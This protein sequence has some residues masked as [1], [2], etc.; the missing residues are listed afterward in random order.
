MGT[1]SDD[2]LA[3]LGLSMTDFLAALPRVQPSATREG[4]GV[5]PDVTWE[6]IGALEAVREELQLN[7]VEPIVH[8]DKYPQTQSTHL[9]YLPHTHALLSD[10]VLPNRYA[11]LGIKVPAG[12]LL[13]GPPGCGKTLLAKAVANESRANFISIKVR[14]RERGRT[15]ALACSHITMVPLKHRDPS[16]WTSTSE[17]QSVLYDKPLPR[18]AHQPPVWS[19]SMSLM[20]WRHGGKAAQ[21]PWGCTPASCR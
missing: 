14:G 1:L 9:R 5:V 6:D 15:A 3:G 17:S 21:I 20:H 19:S 12:V 13:Y 16:C 11:S 4:F 10:L 7:V 2:Q 18:H 8:P